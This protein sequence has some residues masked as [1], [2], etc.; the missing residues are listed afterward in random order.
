MRVAPDKRLDTGSPTN[1]HVL[2][3]KSNGVAGIFIGAI[4]SAMIGGNQARAGRNALAVPP[5]DSNAMKFETTR[6][7]TPTRG[8]RPPRA[9]GLHPEGRAMDGDRSIQGS[10]ASEHRT[11]QRD[12]AGA[13]RPVDRGRELTRRRNRRAFARTRSPGAIE[14]WRLWF[15]ATRGLSP[16]YAS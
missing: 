6:R 9:G 4:N 12:L 15:S 7:R 11:F 14:H 3:L 13:G 16:A 1:I 2:V 5:H 10:G 8:F